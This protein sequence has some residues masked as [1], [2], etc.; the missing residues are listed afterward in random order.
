MRGAPNPDDDDPLFAL[1][2]AQSHD[3]LKGAVDRVK[4]IIKVGRTHGQGIGL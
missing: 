2:T 1:I 3:S 4:E